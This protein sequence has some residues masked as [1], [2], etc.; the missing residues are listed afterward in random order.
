[1]TQSTATGKESTGL[2]NTTYNIISA[3]DSEASFLY[4]T[5][6]RYISD[7]RNENRPDIEGV[8]KIIKESKRKNV[9]ILRE[10]L[11]KEAKQEK[12]AS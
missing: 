1:M 8:W 11:E 10:A 12:L 3:L 6:E 2:D 4:S 5:V 9:R 7:A